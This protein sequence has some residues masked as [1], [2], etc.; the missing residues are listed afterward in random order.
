MIKDIKNTFKKDPAARSVFEVLLCYPGLHAL[1]AHRFSNWLWRHN[2]KF[3]GRLNSHIARFI[4]QI[5]I[6]PGA[7]IGQ[8]FFIDHGCGVVIGE[9][10]IIGDDVLLYK[11]AVLGGTSLSK[12][13]RH[14]TLEDGV[15]VGTN[16]VILGD[17]TIGRNSR[18][19]AGSVVVRSVPAE[20]TVVGIPGRIAEKEHR[21]DQLDHGQLPDPLVVALKVYSETI[22]MLEKRL[23]KLEKDS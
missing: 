15:V 11:G 10:S 13:K 12:G 18:V 20:S 7:V 6:H 8:R 9:T 23:E 5:E 4:T 21:T 19:G 1:W 22:E 2:L 17:I 14:P 16:A 3:F